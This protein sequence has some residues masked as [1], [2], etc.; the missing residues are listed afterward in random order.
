M[1]DTEIADLGEL[2][3]KFDS[4]IV[5]K[6][7]NSAVNKTTNK[8]RTFISK[9]VREAWNVKAK[10][11]KDSVTSTR[12]RD[13]SDPVVE[14]ILIYTGGRISLINFAAKKARIP[15]TKRK[16]ASVVIRKSK[17]RKI[18]RGKNRYGAFI[19]V[20]NN[21]NEHVFLR[22]S[23]DRKSIENRRGPSVAQMVG[24]AEMTKEIDEFVKAEMPKQLEHELDYF[25]NIAGTT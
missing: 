10:K 18:V 9:T 7:L 5:T 20:G 11:I 14:R 24:A 3:K 13:A 2:R 15:G 21:G 19:A 17:G 8:A 25:L 12:L 16:G 1:I 22:A 23:E 6:A 4:K